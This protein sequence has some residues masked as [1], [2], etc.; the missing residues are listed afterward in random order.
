[1]FVSL[2][3]EIFILLVATYSTFLYKYF[4]KTEKSRRSIYSLNC[5]IIIKFYAK[6]ER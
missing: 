5:P 6:V 3:Q 1:M 4:L 2:I